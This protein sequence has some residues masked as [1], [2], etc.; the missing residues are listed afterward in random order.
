MTSEEK[1]KILVDFGN[2]FRKIRRTQDITLED[3]SNMS[4]IAYSTIVKI[5]KG[6]INT[7][8]ANLIKL[9]EKLKVHPSEFFESS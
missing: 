5:E 8:I 4:G 9:A 1:K 3:L 2:R 6:D 7:G